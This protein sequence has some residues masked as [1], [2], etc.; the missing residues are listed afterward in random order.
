LNLAKKLSKHPDFINKYK[1]NTDPFTRKPAF[2][3]MVDS[4]MVT[5]KRDI[6]DLYKLYRNDK[7]AEESLLQILEDLVEMEPV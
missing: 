1:N 7:S 3:K 6:T 2:K 4:L 5:Y